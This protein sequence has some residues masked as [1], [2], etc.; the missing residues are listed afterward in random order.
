MSAVWPFT[1]PFPD[2]LGDGDSI[3]GLKLSRLSDIAA[4]AARGS[5]FTDLAPVKNWKTTTPVISVPVNRTAT[6]DPKS[7]RWIVFG[8]NS[9]NTECWYTISG[10]RWVSATLNVGGSPAF[11]GGTYATGAASAA[12]VILMA[13][14]IGSSSTSKIAESTDGGGTWIRR[15]IGNSDTHA[16]SQLARV[17]SLGLWLASLG[18]TGQDGVFWSSDQVSWTYGG[19]VGCPPSNFVVREGSSKH[20]PLVLGASLQFF[21]GGN[22]YLRSEDGKNWVFHSFPAEMVAQGRGCWHEHGGLFVVPGTG[23]V[24]ASETAKTGSWEKITNTS[25]FASIG[26]FGRALI[27]ADGAGSVNLGQTWNTFVEVASGSDYI[28]KAVE[29]IGVLMSRPSVNLHYMSY[30]VGY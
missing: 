12:G 27:R 6:Y 10:S 2:E 25:S 11:T 13:G 28:V 24:W 9:P 26:S 16:V 23:G 14:T 8:Y 3:A 7:R 4:T 19:G 20:T 1:N 17:E 15:S 29:G 22:N 5:I 30:L 21:P 18:G